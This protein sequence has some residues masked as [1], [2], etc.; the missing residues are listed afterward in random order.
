MPPLLPAALL[1]L[2]VIAAAGGLLAIRRSGAEQGIARRLAGAREVRLS[3]LFNMA[4]LPPRPVRIAGRIRCNDPIVNSRGERLVAWH[5]DVQ[6]QPSG[7]RW[8]SIERIRES[9]GFEL[10][11]HGGSLP[12]DPSDAAEPLVAIPHVWRGSASDLQDEAHLAAVGR[13][14]GGAMPA[15]SITRSV[16]VVERLLVLA[17]VVRDEA[18]AIR[19]RPPPGGYVIS[20]L[21]LADAMRLLGGPRRRLLL[22]G[23]GLLGLALVTV[24]AAALSWLFST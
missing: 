19:L 23:Y 18:G 11:D 17:S 4:D 2:A 6:V 8:R 10:W 7:G 15:R 21:E 9:R 24:L 20:T 12:V 1:L 13:L 5:R 3:E 22:A 16:S 14:G